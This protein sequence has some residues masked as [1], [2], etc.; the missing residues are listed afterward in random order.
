[1]GFVL[2]QPDR[3]CNDP[4]TGWHLRMGEIILT[5]R[6]LPEKDPLSWAGPD[7]VWKNYQ[8]LSQVTMGVAHRAGGLGLVTAVWA[9]VYGLVAVLV[10]RQG[11]RMGAPPSV[12]FLCAFWA[13]L[14]MTMHVQ[15][16]PHA[17]TYLA[18]CLLV[19]LIW[20]ALEHP[21]ERR[22]ALVWVPLLFLVWCNLHGGFVAG[23]LILGCHTAGLLA[24]W[25]WR[26]EREDL[27]AFGDFAVCGAV[28]GAATLVNPYGWNLH[29]HI[30]TFLQVD[31]AHLWNEFS[32]PLGHGSANV[33]LY[34][35]LSAALGV[36]LWWQR[37]WLRAG[38]VLCLVVLFYFSC[39]ALRHV[40]LFA[41]VAA[42]YVA[43]GVYLGLRRWIDLMSPAGRVL[44]GHE[45]RRT[46]LWVYGTALALGFAVLSQTAPGWFRQ[47]FIG[48]R[49]GA[50][51][52]AYIE[53]NRERLEPV[54]NI[55]N[56]G[57]ALA[58]HFGPG[59]GVFVDDRLDRYGR[60]FFVDVY[61]PVMRVEEGWDAILEEWGVASAIVP[62]ESRLADAL[63]EHPDWEVAVRDENSAVFVRR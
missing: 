47:D 32:P 61:L 3:P 53:A 62:S 13:W 20:R 39:Q 34:Y 63:E 58:Y 42:P 19:G 26:R 23:F 49:L 38:D 31:I 8:W 40:V 17:F 24:R 12:A 48:L 51:S 28:A 4:G 45:L 60:E 5:E 33:K 9:V 10:H 11:V 1:M 41:L 55:E 14:I 36:S 30:L 7:V 57:G 35:L 2:S 25:L 21:G 54:F 16:R 52:A 46:G 29:W 22:R 59:L 43:R 6:G 56:L 44:A 27:G 18:V 50:E 15:N 37:R